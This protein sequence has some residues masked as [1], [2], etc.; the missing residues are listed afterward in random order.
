LLTVDV[1]PTYFLQLPQTMN[2]QKSVSV[3][4]FVIVSN[5]GNP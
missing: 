4:S 5:C 3:V 1:K 2:N